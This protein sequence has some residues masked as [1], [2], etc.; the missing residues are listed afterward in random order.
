MSVLNVRI[1]F[2]AALHAVREILDMSVIFRT[3]EPA[4]VLLVVSQFLGVGSDLV[5]IDFDLSLGRFNDCTGSSNVMLTGP[6]S[7]ALKPFCI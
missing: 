4:W 2:L 5:T 7:L 1:R 6:V 3:L